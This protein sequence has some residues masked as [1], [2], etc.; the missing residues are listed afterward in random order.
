MNRRIGSR[1]AKVTVL[2]MLSLFAAPIMAYAAVGFSNLSYV[3]GTVTGSVYVSDDTN[4]GFTVTDDVYID[5]YGSDDQFIT[6]ITDAVYSSVTEDTYGVQTYYFNFSKYVGSHNELKLHERVTDAVYGTATHQ[7]SGGSGGDG[8]NG[9]SNGGGGPGG[10]G[11]SDGESPPST[12][13][14]LRIEAGQSVDADQLEQA[15]ETHGDVTLEIAD[16]SVLLPAEVLS[17]Y[18]NSGSILTIVNGD[19]EYRLP[20]GA[21]DYEQI[22][23]M[24]GLEIAKWSLEVSMPPVTDELREAMLLRMAASGLEP[25]ADQAIDFHVQA[26]GEGDKSLAITDFGSHYV[27]RVFHLEETVDPD[28]TTAVLYDTETGQFYF[29][30]SSVAEK[31]N[32]GAIVTMKRNG[33]SIYTVASHEAAFPDIAGHW[34]EDTIH[35]LGNKLIVEG[36]ASGAYSPER[37]L[38]R[39]ELAAM[40]VRSLGLTPEVY[41]SGTFTDVD[42]DAWYADEVAAAV[43]AGLIEGDPSGTFRPEDRVTREELA[44]M[45]TRAMDFTGHGINLTPS[46]SQDLLVTFE[47]ADQIQWGQLELAAA[48]YQG[49]VIGTPTGLLQSG[50]DATRA[51]A[52]TML[53]RLLIKTQFINE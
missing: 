53:K 39:A 5:V 7:T 25:I 17:K 50:E 28:T 42:A 30:P 31:D 20:L 37:S 4:G 34:A 8:G 12:S 43:E 22:S 24:L 3:D 32:G 46:E 36:D 11:D 18:A 16:A 47:D 51:E 13:D 9:G 52:A 23:K 27:E 41:Q 38:S 26:V 14:V 44:A 2:V 29:V 1:I 49:I 40:L 21:L 35:L 45:M 10:D 6:T 33:N 48:V 19:V 15:L